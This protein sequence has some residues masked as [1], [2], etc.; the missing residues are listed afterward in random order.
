MPHLSSRGSKKTVWLVSLMFEVLH[1]QNGRWRSI[2]TSFKNLSSKG[3]FHISTP[4]SISE[5]ST[6]IMKN[7][8][9][10]SESIDSKK[11]LRTIL[12]ITIALCVQSSTIGNVIDTTGYQK[13]FRTTS[14][15]LIFSRTARQSLTRKFYLHLPKLSH[16]SKYVSRN[17]QR[18]LTQNPDRLS[19]GKQLWEGCEWLRR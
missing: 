10:K 19:Q 12:K 5:V 15:S 9:G 1:I 3:G 6:K 4:E 14:K 13:T 7:P 11:S 17:Y 8:S 18:R 16:F 2:K